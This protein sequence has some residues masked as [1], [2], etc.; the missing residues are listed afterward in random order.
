MGAAIEGLERLLLR[1]GSRGAGIRGLSAARGARSFPFF[2]FPS[3]YDVDFVICMDGRVRDGSAD[4]D[5][6]HL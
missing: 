2:G 5:K 3:P 1:C 6:V 4:I